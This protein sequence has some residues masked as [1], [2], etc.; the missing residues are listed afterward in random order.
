MGEPLVKSIL[1]S[2]LEDEAE[3][4][5]Q[6]QR[7]AKLKRQLAAANHP[8]AAKLVTIA[9]VFVKRNV[10]IIGGDG[11]AYD[12]GFGGLDHVLTTGRDVNILVLDTGVYSNTG[13]QASK[14]TPRGAIAKFAAAG[15]PSR[16]KD[17]GM[18]AVSYGNVYV[19]Q[20]A[21]AANPR[22]PCGPFEKRNPIRAHR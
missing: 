7:V 8:S 10:W 17:L 13:G 2:A 5:E 20:V 9:D 18:L 22:R 6:R 11:W 12:I 4:A 16:K 14:A 1:S 3:L 21:V 19:A 15:K